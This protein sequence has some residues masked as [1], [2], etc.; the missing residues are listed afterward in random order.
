MNK[1][2]TDLKKTDSKRG[3]IKGIEMKVKKTEK[4]DRE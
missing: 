1:R 2:K 4:T 3:Y